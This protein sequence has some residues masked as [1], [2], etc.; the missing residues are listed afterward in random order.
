MSFSNTKRFIEAKCKLL[1]RSLEI[2]DRINAILGQQDELTKLQLQ[3]ILRQVN[4]R[5]KRHNRNMFLAQATSQIAQQ[6]IKNEQNIALEATEKLLRAQRT[7][8]PLI[9]PELD[10]AISLD[11]RLVEFQRLVDELPLLHYL[12]HD[13]DDD[14]ILQR[15]E[16]VRER[17]AELSRKFG[18]LYQK[19]AY[20]ENLLKSIGDYTPETLSVDLALEIDRFHEL[21]EKK[22]KSVN[23]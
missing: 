2:D 21:V 18:H 9:I 14:E 5:M 8:Q 23:A 7:V 13:D 3:H 12:R 16:T 4:V 22:R 15:Y 6:V 19:R 10:S 20:L 17:L 11:R 1:D